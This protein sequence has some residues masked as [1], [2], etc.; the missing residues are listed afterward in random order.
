[1]PML[2]H[3]DKVHSNHAS[4]D[5]LQEFLKMWVWFLFFPSNPNLLSY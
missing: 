4:F 1:M 3:F 2:L 5:V